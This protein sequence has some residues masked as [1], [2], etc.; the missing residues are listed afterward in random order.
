M[1]RAILFLHVRRTGGIS[2][3]RL[4]S[5]RFAVRDCLTAAHAPE[6]FARDPSRFRF[7][8]G[9]VDL[10]YGRRFQRPPFVLTCLRDPIERAVSAYYL[11][12]AETPETYE[13]FRTQYSPPA[14]ARRV[15]AGQAMRQHDLHAFVTREPALA[16]EFLG[17]AHARVLADPAPSPGDER[18]DAATAGLERCDL[19]LVTE[20][21]DAAVAWLGSRLGCGPLGPMPRDNPAPGRPDRDALDGRTLDALAALTSVDRPLY[22]L[23]TELAERRLR[24]WREAGGRADASLEWDQP[25]DGGDYDFDQPI[26]GFG[27]LGREL[28]GG[29]WLSWIGPGG[30]W[31]DLSTRGAG[32]HELRCG[33][34]AVAAPS[35]LDGVRLRVNGCRVEHACR[36]LDQLV[37]LGGMVPAAVIARQRGVARIEITVAET[38]RPCDVNPASDDRRQLGIAL[39]HVRLRPR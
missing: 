27:W 21:L 17:N 24:E 10:A 31:L 8:E 9:H 13:T 20:R 15:A 26:H 38:A 30:A 35:V 28:H 11:M 2:L 22:R 23:G 39:R 12:R 18:L 16:A 1:R 32:D 7:V 6:H 14:L 5:T 33:V 4:L 29:R 37:E 36:Q 3:L 34:A 25:P 19:V